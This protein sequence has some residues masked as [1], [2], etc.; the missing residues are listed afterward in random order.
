MKSFR[1]DAIG[2]IAVSLFALGCT[3]SS[4]PSSQPTRTEAPPVV[5]TFSLRGSVTDTA[6]RSLSGAIVEVLDGPGAGTV[7]TV[8]G[9]GH[10]SMPGTFTGTVMV[11]ASKDGY[12]TQ[13]QAVAVVWRPGVPVTAEFQRWVAFYLESPDPPT[14][15]AGEYSLS[16]IVDG[17]CSGWPRDAQSRHYTAMISQNT[18]SRTSFRARLGGARFYSGLAC[19][20]APPDLCPGYSVSIGVAGNYASIFLNIIEPTH[21]KAR[22]SSS[23]SPRSTFIQECRRAWPTCSSTPSGRVVCRSSS[24]VTATTCCDGCSAELLKSSSLLMKPPCISPRQR[25][26]SLALRLSSWTCLERSRTGQRVSSAT[27][28]MKSLP[29]W[30]RGQPLR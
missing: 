18:N 2:L 5:L 20:G 27:S 24:R 25:T 22:H 16:L 26:A 11:R 23:S 14:N 13:T 7:A 17:A 9:H 21:Q 29:R 19:P 12:V 1:L 4:A 15:I 8:D 30:L 28:S 6:Y 10:F 3:A